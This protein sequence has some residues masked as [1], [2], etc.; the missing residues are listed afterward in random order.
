MNYQATKIQIFS[1]PFQIVVRE[2][3]KFSIILKTRKKSTS[4]IKALSKNKK[5]KQ[6]RIKDINCYNFPT[7]APSKCIS[8]ENE[9]Q[10]ETQPEIKT[11]KC[12]NCDTE[13]QGKFCPECGQSAETGRFTLRF[14]WENLISA[15]FGS[16]GGIWFTFKNMFTRPG[17]MMVEI[18]DGKRRKYFSP[19]PMLLLV[20]TIYILVYSI[21]GSR[22]YVQKVETAVEVSKDEGDQVKYVAK[23]TISDALHFYNDNYTLCYLLTL[24]LLAFAARA[25]FGRQ[26]RKRYNWAEYII[27]LVYASVFVILYRILMSLAYLVSPDI[28]HKMV[29]MLPIIIIIALTA[30]FGKVMGFGIAKTFLRS[31]LTFALYFLMIIS[32]GFTALAIITICQTGI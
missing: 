13:F 17:K 15:L 21:T 20:L 2:Q 29:R 11:T 6:Q 25:C 1:K 4:Q 30:C 10:S 18:L 12:L 31:V 26:N 32:L 5:T 28:S 3:I 9:I 7:F 24:P 16:Y 8:M 27:L 14:I 19:F 23:K 22:D